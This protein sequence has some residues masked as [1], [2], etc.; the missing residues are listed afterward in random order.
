MGEAGDSRN[1]FGRRGHGACRACGDHRS[2][3]PR[4]KATDFG[5]DQSVAP[6]ARFDCAAFRENPRPSCPRNLEEFE[7]KLPITIE[8]FRHELIEPLPGNFAHGHVV[9]QAREI[10][11]KCEC[12]RRRI[13]NER[14][15]SGR[16]CSNASGPLC[17]QSRQQQ[18]PLQI[19]ESG[20]KLQLVGSKVCARR[21]REGNLVLI[22]VAESDDAR[23]DGG[24][25]PGHIQKDVA[26]DP[27]GPT[28]RQVECGAGEGQRIAICWKSGNELPSEQRS[29]QRRQKRI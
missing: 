9:D 28:C 12:G 10:I 29:D 3:A 19:P 26:C 7:C 1:Q 27:A 25:L 6:G 14:R 17:D 4:S 21:L 24:F 18:S 8:I 11:G 16:L 13:G 2:I 22:D 15:F 5:L 20:R 23:K